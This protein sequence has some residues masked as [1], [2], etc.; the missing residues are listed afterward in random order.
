MT[1]WGRIQ[2]LPWHWEVIFEGL[3]RIDADLRLDLDALTELCGQRVRQ[4][5][6]RRLSQREPLPPAKDVTT[7][8]CWGIMGIKVQEEAP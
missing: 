5:V 3:V 7:H 2:R 4:E 8:G 1:Y 6:E